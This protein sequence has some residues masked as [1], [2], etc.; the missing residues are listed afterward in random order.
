[1]AYIGNWHFHIVLQESENTI[2][3]LMHFMKTL[4]GRLAI[5]SWWNLPSHLYILTLF[6]LQHNFISNA[7]YE[8]I[9][10]RLWWNHLYILTTQ[11]HL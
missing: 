10:G 2:S 3:S 11:F 4:L 6:S 8:N 7:F 9:V 5:P 1:M